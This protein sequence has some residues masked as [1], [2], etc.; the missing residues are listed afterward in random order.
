[1]LIEKLKTHKS[2]KS[3]IETFLEHYPLQS[4]EGLA[5]MTL[6]EALLRIPDN[7]TKD[8][9]IDEKISSA[10]WSKAG[11]NDLFLKAAG[12]GLSLA[13]KTLGSFLGGLGRP[14]IRKSLEE[15]VKRI[16]HQFVLGETID[17][18]L[19]NSRWLQDKG[20]R[21]SY[22]MLGEGARTREDA[23]RYFNAYVAASN[24]IGATGSGVPSQRNG[25]S[26]KLSALHPRYLWTQ[27]K[28]CVPEIAEKLL[29]LSKIAAQYNMSLTVDAEEADRLEL[30]LKIIET[31]LQ[32]KSLNEWGGFGLAIQAY[33]KRCFRLVDDIADLAKNNS[34][35]IQVRLVKG[36]Y[37]DSEIK[38][39]QMAGLSDYPLYTRKDNT[40]LSYLAC[41]DKLLK[42]RDYIYPMFATHNAQSVASVLEL[43][44]ENRNG[45]EFQRLYGMGETLGDIVVTEK[46]APVCIY[47]PV[48]SYED[49]LPYLVRRMLENGANT[50]FL[51]KLR[52]NN[53]DLSNDLIFKLKSRDAHSHANIPSP[54]YIYPDRINS[55]GADFSAQET[56][57]KFRYSLRV[58]ASITSLIGD[59]GMKT[60]APARIH[61]PGSVS[62]D[63]GEVWDA[64]PQLI[65]PAFAAAQAGHAEWSVFPSKKRAD[66]LRRIADLI[67]RDR[68]KLIAILRSEGGRTLLDSLSEVREAADFC[69][70]YALHGEKIFSESGEILVGPTGESNKIYHKPRGVFVSI[71]PWNFPLAIF[72]GQIVAALMAGNAVIAKPAEQTPGI[73]YHAVR[74]MREAG[75][76]KNALTLILGEGNIG[77]ALVSNRNVKGVVFTGSTEVARKINRALAAK[78]GDIV[79][80]I[81][82]TGGQNAMIVDSSALLEQVVDDVVVSAFGSAG[83]R[84]S[85]LRVVYIQEEVA[86]RFCALLK[87]AM[88]ELRLGDARDIET[89]IGPVI[90]SEALRALESHHVYL[91]KIGKAVGEVPKTQS[92]NGCYFAP[93]AYEINSID[94]LKGEVFGPVLHIIRYRG[95]DRDRV[96]EQVNSTGYGLT[97]GLHSRLSGQFDDIAGRVQAGNIYINRSM[98]GAVVGVQPFGGMGLS[99]TGPKAGGPNYLHRFATEKTISINTT[100]TG[101]NI[102]LI[103]LKDE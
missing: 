32:D 21:L 39:T 45:F 54:R 17:G 100:A 14:V 64:T 70:Y 71:S 77:S 26:V 103:S 67:E 81:A 30:S 48:G 96:I 38:R 69:R 49:L 40:D 15:A 36:A 46:M 7:D 63:S 20:Y 95:K 73:A 101:G 92:L 13:R 85:A 87:G 5:L 23:E 82:E 8:R 99:G 51:N 19:K 68:E 83:Q 33:D 50:S 10:D 66:I 44:G 93:V 74:L 65:E 18:A 58:K 75:V 88:K 72:T 3:E 62:E 22:D 86:D 2:G 91:K 55:A 43:A 60:Q 24:K 59:E 28:T 37:W 1:M 76:P 52:E 78:D 12:T 61:L 90:D 56:R 11:G 35:K 94:E 9:L 98:I 80:L 79:P 102:A 89:D 34:R 97:F 27:E 6:A 84:C 31:V 41:A 57:E 29:H 25:M 53:D 16:G 42:Y 4:D 47:A